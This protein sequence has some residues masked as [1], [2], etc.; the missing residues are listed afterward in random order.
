M[1]RPT[2]PHCDICGAQKSDVNY[3][4]VITPTTKEFRISP[5][6][7]SVAP[8]PK[9]AQDVCGRGCAA[10]ALSVWMGKSRGER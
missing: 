10:V 3:W 5:A 8:L 7:A 9:P 2:I 1:S 6:G 4:Y